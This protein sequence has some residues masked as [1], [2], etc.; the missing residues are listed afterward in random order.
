M[1]EFCWLCEIRPIESIKKP[2]CKGCYQACRKK[3][4]LHIF[5]TTNQDLDG[6]TN[7]INKYGSGLIRDMNILR[8]GNTTLINIGNKYGISRERIR[9]LY[10]MFFGENYTPTVKRRIE[11]RKTLEQIKDK[12]KHLFENR[13]SRAQKHCNSYTAIIAENLFLQKCKI[14]GYDITMERGNF[15]YDATVNGIPVDVKSCSAASNYQRYHTGHQLYYHFNS[16]KKQ[17]ESV[18]FF[19]FYLFDCDIWYIIPA[20]NL[21]SQTYFLPKYDTNY[22]GMHKYREVQKYREAWHLLKGDP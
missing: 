6:K 8:S 7:A 4:L 2:L 5:P 3:K 20:K 19:P 17:R 16:R 13:L 11:T 10:P 1:I 12:E 14:L 9:Q 21:N 22:N 18:K 15:L